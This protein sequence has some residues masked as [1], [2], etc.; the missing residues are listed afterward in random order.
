MTS[1][2]AFLNYADRLLDGEFGL[3]ARGP[4]I[5]A[6]LARSVL[7][8]WIEEQSASWSSPLLG[9][10]TTRSKIVALGA[11]RGAEVGERTRRIWHRLSRAVHHHAYELQPSAAE[12]RQL[13]G[14][15][16]ELQQDSSTIVS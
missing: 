16:R 5:A 4:R 8:E 9:Y 2:V 6:L 13:V 3:D 11:V 1:R 7:E 12:I 10:P 15:V 14:A